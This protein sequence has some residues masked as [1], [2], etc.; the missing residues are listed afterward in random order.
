VPWLLVGLGRAWTVRTPDATG[1]Q[2]RDQVDGLDEA[3][4]L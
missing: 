3:A 1:V 4:V 2:N